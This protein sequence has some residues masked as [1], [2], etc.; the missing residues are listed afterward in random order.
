MIANLPIM[1]LISRINTLKRAKFIK[2]IISREIIVVSG[3]DYIEGQI[4]INDF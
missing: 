3:E 1:L 4:G 2:A